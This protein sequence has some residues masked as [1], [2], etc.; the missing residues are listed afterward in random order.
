MAR[1]YG[2]MSY[3]NTKPETTIDWLILGLPLT[4][5][6]AKSDELEKRVVGR[7]TINTKGISVEIKRARVFPQPLRP[8]DA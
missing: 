2:A 5:C 8:S 1:L 6:E 3:L 4:T 7:H